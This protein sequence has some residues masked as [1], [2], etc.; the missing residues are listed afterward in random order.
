MTEIIVIAPRD[1]AQ[2]IGGRLWEV[3]RYALEGHSWQLL[4]TKEEVESYL[5]KKTDAIRPVLFALSLGESGINLEYVRILRYLREHPTA[6]EGFVGGVL[7]DGKSD[8]YTKSAARELVFTAN[9]AGCTFVG[10]PLVEGTRT[11]SNFS[12]VARNMDTDLATAY[13][14]SA[15]IL[16]K[17]ILEFERPVSDRPNLLVLH[18]SSHKNSN[19]FAIWNAVKERLGD[20]TIT[21]I[22]LRNGTLSDCSGCPYK[23]CLHFGENES[24]FYGGVMVEAVY[25][26]VKKADAILMLCPNYNDAISA[27]LTAFINRLTALFRTTRFY[28][29][30]LFAIVVSGYSG[31][32]IVAEQLVAALN[33]NKTFY[34][35]GRFAMMETAND[36]GS[37]MK[38]PE[39]DGRIEA[40][41][42]RI[43]ST[44]Q[45]VKKE[46]Y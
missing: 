33:M 29:K 26:A 40:F 1:G 16:V 19:T 21:E 35:P 37:A 39:I 43:R 5:E 17:E 3:L 44:L 8:L 27:N 25:P 24:C 22:G 7:A 28:D 45:T 38:L 41:A 42:G 32:D 14:K 20:F 46:V 9:C 6:L 18:A 36:P 12:I 31:S 11:L 2:E 4:G 10:R 23:M 34:L 15:A 13:K 30:A